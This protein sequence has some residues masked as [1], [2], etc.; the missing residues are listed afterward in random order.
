MNA[1]VY[2]LID[3]KSIQRNVFIEITFEPIKSMQQDRVSTLYIIVSHLLD[4]MEYLRN[5]SIQFQFLNETLSIWM[6]ALNLTIEI[7]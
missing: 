2:P 3:V 6:A 7:F 5:F 4:E 1:F